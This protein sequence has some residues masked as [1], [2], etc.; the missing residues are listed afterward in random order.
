MPL[1]GRVNARRDAILQLTVYAAAVSHTIDV[2]VDTG[3]TGSLLLPEPVATALN[4]SVVQ[5]TTAT[6]ADGSLA[7]FRLCRCEVGWVAGQRAILA[8][9]GRHREALLGTTLLAGQRLLIDYGAATVEI[10]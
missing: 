2:I 10:T 4:L 6:L 7:I 8:H 9:I 1:T 5:R 3:F